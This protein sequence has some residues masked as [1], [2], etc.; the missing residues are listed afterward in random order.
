MTEQT[1]LSMRL[2]TLILYALIRASSYVFTERPYRWE[3]AVLDAIGI[4]VVVFVIPMIVKHLR[5]KR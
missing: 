5:G 4:V 3:H 1:T 2:T